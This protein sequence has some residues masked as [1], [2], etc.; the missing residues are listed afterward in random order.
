MAT[1]PN[2][3]APDRDP[4]LCDFAEAALGTQEQIDTLRFFLGALHERVGQV[5]DELKPPEPDFVSGWIELSAQ[6]GVLLSADATVGDAVVLIRTGPDEFETLPS[7]PRGGD[8]WARPYPPEGNP[9]GAYVYSRADE[10]CEVRLRG[11]YATTS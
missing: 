2:T 5:E 8:V 10:P 7:S 11:W 4:A 1:L 6:G 9:R 3:L